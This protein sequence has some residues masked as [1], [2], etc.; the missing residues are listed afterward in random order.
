MPYE[1]RV[2][3]FIQNYYETGMEYESLLVTMKD[4]NLDSFLWY[5][6]M[7]SIPKYR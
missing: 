5:G 1:E 2:G 6:E 4:T 7:I 3:W